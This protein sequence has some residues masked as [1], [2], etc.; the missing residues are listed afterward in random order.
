MATVTAVVGPVTTTAQ[1]GFGAVVGGGEGSGTA[2]SIFLR[3][4][5]TSIRVKNSGGNETAVIEAT[6]KDEELGAV[7][8]CGP[9]NNIRFA[10]I[11]G[12]GG[13]EKLDGGG[14]V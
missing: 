5:P 4:E 3:I 13:G 11:N 8:D 2:N 12:P 1:V 9:E 14:A 7:T 6:V 10:I